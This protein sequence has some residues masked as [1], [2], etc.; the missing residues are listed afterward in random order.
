[1]MKSLNLLKRGLIFVL[2]I[3]LILPMAGCKQDNS[4][5]PK[6]ETV[7][8]ESAVS[9][10]ASERSFTDSLGRE[11]TLPA[12][13][14]RVVVSGPLAEIAVFAICP[15]KL[16]GIAMEPNEQQLKYLGEE[17]GKLPVIGQLYGGKEELNLETLLDVDP[18]VII[19]VGEEKDNMAEDLDSIQ[20]QTGVPFVH[21]SARLSNLGDTYKM[22][23]ELVGDEETGD[24]LSEYCTK[25]YNRSKEI[26]EKLEKKD[27]LYILGDKGTNVLAKGS[28]HSEVIDMMT[29]NIAEVDSPSSKGSGNE[30]DMEQ[31]YNWDPKTLIIAPD[32]IYFSIDKDE[33]WQKVSAVKNKSYYLVPSGPYNWM[34]F[35]PSVQRL[36]A[37][38]WIE[39]T[40]YP[41]ECDYDLY[42]EVATYYDYFYH[43]DLT[44]EEYSKL[45]NPVE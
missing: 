3:T 16:V 44:E 10:E 4:S 20:E 25:V 26:S 2:A 18:Q 9:S 1:M 6:E 5:E 21:I 33:L 35:P 43:Y 7:T 41:E 15:D 17:Y 13:I 11:V 12:E 34:G 30:V 36:L 37:M 32:S 8:T 27:V 29:N 39:S 23:G 24:K 19:D 14:D 38:M 45:I 22:L 40:L 31:I 28:F 42:E